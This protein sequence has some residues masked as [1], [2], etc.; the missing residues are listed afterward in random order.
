MKCENG[1]AYKLYVR[2]CECVCVCLCI[3]V[4]NMEKEIVSEKEREE[5]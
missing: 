3:Y 2:E 4:K 1:A 5:R